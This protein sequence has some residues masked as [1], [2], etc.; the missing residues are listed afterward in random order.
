[1]KFLFASLKHLI[2]LIIL[3][4]E[5]SNF[6]SSFP[7]LS[8]VDFFTFIDGFRNNFSGSQA[9][10]EKTFRDVGGYQKAGTNSLKRVTGKRISQIVSD[11]TEASR[12][13]IL[14]FLHKK[15][16]KKW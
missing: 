9:G 2:I 12:S 13:F 7:F 5:A 6:Y 11:F 14:D 4:K 10:F 16:T 1:M 8:L 15:T 3:S